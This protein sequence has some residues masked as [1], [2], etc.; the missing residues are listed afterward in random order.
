VGPGLALQKQ[1]IL[2]A[3][4]A[5]LQGAQGDDLL[6]AEAATRLASAVIWTSGGFHLLLG[7]RDGALCDPYYPAYASMRADSASVM[8]AYY[9]FVVRYEN[10]LSDLR[11]VMLPVAEA[12]RRIRLESI[13]LSV[14]GGAG[15]VW[16][17]VRQM[18]Q[19]STVS[20]INLSTIPDLTKRLQKMRDLYNAY[21]SRD[22]V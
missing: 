22:E 16:A 6:L 14:T 5:P 17:M 21:I 2:A 11:M 12:Q 15:K 18:P 3:Y 9:D 20:L 10:I 8:R 4:L 7:E 1:V 19:F 13:A